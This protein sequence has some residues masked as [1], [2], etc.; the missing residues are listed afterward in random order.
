MKLSY[1]PA[2][3]SVLLLLLASCD[4]PAVPTAG[5]PPATE[6]TAD[7][8]D[9]RAQL[10]AEIA[11]LRAQEQEAAYRLLQQQQVEVAADRARLERERVEWEEEKEAAARAAAAQ[12]ADAATP[13]PARATPPVAPARPANPPRTVSAPEDRD[14]QMFYEGLAP[15]GQWFESDEYGWVW[16]PAAARA[17]DW[18]PY[19]RGR[20]VD[21]DQGWAW[22]S[23]E[24]FGWATYHYGRWALLVNHGWIW[25]PGETWAPAWVAWRRNEECVGWAPLPPETS[26]ADDITYGPEVEADYGLSAEWYTFMPVRHFDE[27]VITHCRP[28]TENVQFFGVTVSIT[29]V[30]VRRDRVLCGGPE[31]RWIND[32]IARP[33]PRHSIHRRQE[34]RNRDDYRTQIENNRLSCYSPR[35]RAEWNDGIRPSRA[36]GRLDE[37]R[38]VRREESFR[39]EFAQRYHG[40][41]DQRRERAEVA[42]QN[43]PTRRLAERHADLEKVRARRVVAEDTRDNRPGRDQTPPDRTSDTA[44]PSVE[45]TAPSTAITKD[46]QERQEAV[47]RREEKRSADEPTTGNKDDRPAIEKTPT[48]SGRPSVHQTEKAQPESPRRDVADRPPGGENKGN[49]D[50]GRPTADQPQEKSRRDA[51]DRQKAAE[52]RERVEQ[53]GRPTPQDQEKS[54]RDIAERQEAAEANARAEQARRAQEQPQEKNRQEAADRQQQAEAAERAE[55]TRQAE[56]QAQEKSR[57]KAVDPKELTEQNNRNQDQP[58]EKTSRDAAARRE[59]AEARERAEQDRRTQEQTQEK[60]RQPNDERRQAAE[61]KERAEQSRRVQEQQNAQKQEQSRQQADERRQGNEA[62]ERAEQSRRLQEQQNAQKQEQSRQQ[63]DERRQANEA[64]ERAEQSRRAQESDNNDRRREAA[65]RQR[66]SEERSRAEESRRS[67]DREAGE[68]QRNAERRQQEEKEARARSEK[69]DDSRGK[70]KS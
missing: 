31:P 44:R 37:V 62:K 8:A 70:Q 28:M 21:S 6:P 30:V 45:P 23:D 43:E 34:W 29:N 66:A 35:V 59:A 25:V 20:W 54:R 60:N 53:G 14:Y 67:Q 51:N 33:M 2:W 7:L 46:R 18:R 40:Q 11:T 38:V 39:R 16:R 41:R 58:Q 15:H 69:A 63:A 50:Q 47:A 65:E 36:Q 61:A 48:Q 68:R 55:R 3:L 12:A 26:Y 42:L 17:T 49:A 19:T 52:A 57:P 4:R 13:E 32:C 64:K 24:P 10:E 27:P 1:F 5:P 9:E 22:I 56:A